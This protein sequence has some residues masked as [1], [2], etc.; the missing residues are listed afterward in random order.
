MNEMG[1]ACGTDGRQGTCV[2]GFWWGVNAA[3]SQTLSASYN[4]PL[5]RMELDMAGLA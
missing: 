2:A 4:E 1:G 5:K 3:Q